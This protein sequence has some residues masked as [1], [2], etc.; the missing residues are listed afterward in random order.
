ME[1]Y[2]LEQNQALRRTSTEGNN[3]PVIFVVTV[4]PHVDLSTASY[5]Y[6]CIAIHKVW[7][8]QDAFKFK[9][10]VVLFAVWGCSNRGEGG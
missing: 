8:K 2:V 7:W 5:C 10:M 1:T 3:G 4:Y 9:V 6:H